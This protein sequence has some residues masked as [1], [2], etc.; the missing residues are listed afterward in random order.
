MTRWVS[1]SKPVKALALVVCEAQE[2]VNVSK[3]NLGSLWLVYFL[4]NMN[5]AR[6]H[7]NTDGIWS[8]IV[9]SFNICYAIYK[10][11]G[12][13]LINLFASVSETV[14]GTGI[15][16]YLPCG[17]RLNEIYTESTCTESCQ[18]KQI[19]FPFF[20]RVSEEL[21]RVFGKTSGIW[22]LSVYVSFTLEFY[23]WPC[24]RFV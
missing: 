12:L 6:S 5:W 15:V 23:I 10:L 1:V 14:R 11:H 4:N 18:L 19:Y 3:E 2:V 20:L 7:G 21:W 8:Q 22:F 24:S 16:V 17:W 13:G 9:L